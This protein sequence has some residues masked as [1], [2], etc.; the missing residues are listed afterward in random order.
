MSA[1]QPPPEQPEASVND[2]LIL[3]TVD[4]KGRDAKSAALDRIIAAELA[5]VRCE[6][7]G[8]RAARAAALAYIEYLTEADQMTAGFLHCHNWRYEEEFL[9]R[10][11]Q[12]RAAMTASA[13][14]KAGREE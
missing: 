13:T 4:G 1:N 11:E 9:N 3:L 6:L 2:R 14:G 10:G 12:L 5:A 8:E 7:E